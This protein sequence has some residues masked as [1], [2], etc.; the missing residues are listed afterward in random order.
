MPEVL[1]TTYKR[2]IERGESHACSGDQRVAHVPAVTAPQAWQDFLG[3]RSTER[4]VTQRD[5]RNKSRIQLFPSKDPR[6][7]PSSRR[8]I[9]IFLERVLTNARHGRAE[10]RNPRSYEIRELSAS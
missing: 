1:S 2:H 8:Y 10:P 7:Y 4:R 3:Q 5:Q 9:A 6:T